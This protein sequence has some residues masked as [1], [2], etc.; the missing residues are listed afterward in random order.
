MNQYINIENLNILCSLLYLPIETLGELII[1]LP[2]MHYYSKFAII[3]T[4]QSMMNE[5]MTSKVRKCPQCITDFSA[6]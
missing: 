1:Y 4:C 3:Q 5:G 2:C 6:K